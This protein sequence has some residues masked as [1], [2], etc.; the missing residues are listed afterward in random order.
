[1]ADRPLRFSL[2]MIV[3]NGGEFLRQ[4]LDAV[5][6]FAYEIIVVEG[7]ERNAW[8]LANPDGSSTDDTIQILRSYPDPMGKLKVIRG[9]WRDKVEQSNAYMA[10]A[11]GDYVW[12]IDDD[13][14]YKLTDLERVRQIL[15]AEPQTTAVAFHFVNFF[16]S[17]HRVMVPADAET[18]E[19]WRV[20]RFEPG[21]RFISHRPPTVLDP[22]TGA[23]MNKVCPIRA[24][25]TAQ[26]GIYFYHYSYMTDRQVREK[27][28][29]HRNLR[30]YEA[31][32]GRHL[33]HRAALKLLRPARL[34]RLHDRLEERWLK[35]PGVAERR[36][37]RDQANFLYDYY[38][39]VW[40]PWHSDPERVEEQYGVSPTIGQYVR[41]EP[42]TGT[43]PE[44]IRSHP[45]YRKEY[46][47]D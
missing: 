41:T 18:L 43:H 27:G 17:L 5:Y 4:T 40:L 34:R 24:S 39:R 22:E 12:Q 2:G 8:C 10:R 13:E 21:Y 20:F 3:F 44:A 1:M 14:I 30:L 16:G 19:I 46:N 7:A 35:V 32:V 33:L 11:T 28:V 45:L 31:R 23:I 29:Y 42:F 47:L 6:D 15:G 9:K 36:L 38:E 37:R 25:R 26:E